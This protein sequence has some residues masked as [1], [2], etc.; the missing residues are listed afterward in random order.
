MATRGFSLHIPPEIISLVLYCLYNTR[1]I[2]SSSLVSR[3]W[4][5]QAFPHLHR[6]ITIKKI[7][8]LEMLASRIESNGIERQIGS[9]IRAMTIKLSFDDPSHPCFIR[10]ERAVSRFVGLELLEWK[11]PL[12]S[13]SST[14]FKRFRE[15]CPLLQHLI[16]HHAGASSEVETENVFVFR[17]LKRLDI[18]W[19]HI[20]GY[21]GTKHYLFNW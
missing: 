3:T 13:S 18:L 10:F 14:L 21:H 1:D 20:G 6:H 2:S 4:Y 8:H 11:C 15:H 17:N 12:P 9:C 7:S 19:S 5:K 16:V